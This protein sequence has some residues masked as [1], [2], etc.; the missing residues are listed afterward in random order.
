MKLIFCLITIALAT[1]QQVQA[2]GAAGAIAKQRAKDV[3]N[4][5]NVRQGV[6]APA[7]PAQPPA[8]QPGRP[9]PPD[10]VAKLKADIAAITGNSAVPVELK[11]QFTTNLMACA[12]GSRKPTLA[13]VEKFAGSLSAALAGKGIE[14]SVQ[15]RLVQDINLALNSA[16]LS[17]QRTAEVGD[18]VQAILQTAG[19]TRGAAVNI[20][21]ELKAIAA[22]L[23]AP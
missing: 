7:A 6:G 18:D 21:G 4:Q 9:L 20:T 16:S 10:P 15:T 8:A 22:E 17:A 23:Q 12:R 19:L 2:Q 13:T 5:N 11:K 3:V 14:P 1:A